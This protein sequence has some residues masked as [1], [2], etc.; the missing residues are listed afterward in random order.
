MYHK[1]IWNSYNL[2]RTIF[3]PLNLFI[4]FMFSI[5]VIYSQEYPSVSKI[6]F[7]NT[8]QILK[9]LPII[10][11][12]EKGIK[13]ISI[14]VIDF[15]AT[16]CAPCLRYFP[17]IFEL[18][19]KFEGSSIGFFLVTNE[20]K[21]VVEKFLKRKKYPSKNNIFFIS[22]TT[23]KL[24]EKY[25]IK[26]IPQIVIVDSEDKIL[27]N[28]LPKSLN[29]NL[30]SALFKK[31]EPDYITSINNNNKLLQ[32]LDSNNAYYVNLNIQKSKNN[33]S[34]SMNMNFKDSGVVISY[35]NYKIS[36]IIQNLY[37][38]NP[39]NSIVKIADTSRWNIEFYFRIQDIPE[40]KTI[41]AKILKELFK[42]HIDE[43]YKI[44]DVYILECKNPELLDQFKV[45]PED[46]ERMEHITSND[47]TIS[48]AN[49]SLDDLCKVLSSLINIPV[50]NKCSSPNKYNIVFDY[51]GGL[52][53]IQK[54]LLENY[55]LN[56][57]PSKDEV[58]YFEI[59]NN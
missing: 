58:K 39:S 3:A 7:E 40:A 8:F 13:D 29:K 53:Q 46:Y 50:I 28:G 37:N 22:D 56:L 23:T 36:E 18:G 6:D 15:W 32:K 49:I 31:N 47:S 1:L 57:V 30:L 54:D 55:G 48:S 9:T 16:W 43:K 35:S 38:I 17:H 25:N 4:Y 5:N 14:A 59:R 19:E 26:G 27:W 34:T 52:N 44:S 12:K 20:K 33:K 24:F 10:N 41:L 21:N 51:I 2:R 42:I 11:E 45:N